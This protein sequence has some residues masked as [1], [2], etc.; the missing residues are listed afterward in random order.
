MDDINLDAFA[1]EVRDMIDEEII[2]ELIEI[3]KHI[4]DK[5]SVSDRV[6]SII[7]PDAT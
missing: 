5:K 3:A 7:F 4:N 6:K 2:K 1:K